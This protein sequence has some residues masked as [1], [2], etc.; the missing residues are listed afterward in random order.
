MYVR[1]PQRIAENITG[2]IHQK[3]W[4]KVGTS[5]ERRCSAY[6]LRVASISVLL[7]VCLAEV[8]VVG[9]ICSSL[10]KVQEP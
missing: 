6:G 3:I 8:E 10:R 1:R 2:Y 7:L 5:P 4:A 9:I